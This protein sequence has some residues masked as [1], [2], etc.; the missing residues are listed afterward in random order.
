MFE[1]YPDIMTVRDVMSALDIGRR[2]VYALI[3]NGQLRSFRMGPHH[4]ICKS[5]LSEYVITR[6]NGCMPNKP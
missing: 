4:R 6:E 1:D 5:A 2:A 3:H